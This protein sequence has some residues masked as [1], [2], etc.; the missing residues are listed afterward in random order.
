MKQNDDNNAGSILD[1]ML[2]TLRKSE[3]R[4]EDPREIPD[5]VM[6]SIKDLSHG[7]T[8]EIPAQASPIRYLTYAQRLLT[9]A[10]VC[11]LILYG[12]EEFIIVRKMNTLE[13]HTASFKVEPANTLS[14]ILVKNNLTI[15]SLQQRFPG[16]LKFFAAKQY[17]SQDQSFHSLKTF[18]P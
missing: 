6:Q 5:K 13:T 1:A 2:V 3:P 7:K 18:I 12:V 16:R 10:S 8:D 4:L 9:A 11:L 17:L 14:K 15:Q